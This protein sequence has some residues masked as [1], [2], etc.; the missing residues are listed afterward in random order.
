MLLKTKLE[1]YK[2]EN[3]LHRYGNIVLSVLPYT[4]G[5]GCSYVV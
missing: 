3:Q 4:P 1:I 2:L 5:A